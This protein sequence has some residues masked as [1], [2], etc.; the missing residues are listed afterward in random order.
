MIRQIKLIVFAGGNSQPRNKYLPNANRHPTRCKS[1][2]PKGNVTTKYKNGDN[3]SVF[4]QRRRKITTGMWV[5]LH[6]RLTF[7]CS[8]SFYFIAL[9]IACRSTLIANNAIAVSSFLVHIVKCEMI[10]VRSFCHFA[11]LYY[12]LHVHSH[13]P[14]T[15][16]NLELGLL[17]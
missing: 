15:I 12:Q 1:N 4:Y 13:A 17:I 5:K 14:H 11:Y 3:N 6:A 16:R 9:H 7:R 10:Y 8:A 2:C